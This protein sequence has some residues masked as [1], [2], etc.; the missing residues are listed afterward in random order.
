MPYVSSSAIYRIEYDP[1][2]Q[3]LHI[4]FRASGGPYTYYDVPERVY[5]AFLASSSKGVFFAQH[6]R[7]RHGR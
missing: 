2:T 1:E 3:R 6:I 4:W 5:R 7:D